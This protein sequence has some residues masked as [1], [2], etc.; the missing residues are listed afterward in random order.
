MHSYHT[1]IVGQV[2]DGLQLYIVQFCSH[3]LITN[4]NFTFIICFYIT[5][6][7]DTKLYIVCWRVT[8]CGLWLYPSPI[9]II[10]LGSLLCLQH[11]ALRLMHLSPSLHKLL[12][13]LWLPHHRLLLPK[14]SAQLSVASLSGSAIPFTQALENH[15][16]AAPLKQNCVCVCE[17]MFYFLIHCL[18]LVGVLFSRGCNLSLFACVTGTLQ[19]KQKRATQTN[20]N[21]QTQVQIP[22]VNPSNGRL[23]KTNIKHT[24]D[25]WSTHSQTNSQ[26]VSQAV[27]DFLYY[28]SLG[29]AVVAIL[30]FPC[31]VVREC[32]CVHA[33][34]YVKSVF[35]SLFS[36]MCLTQQRGGPS[37]WQ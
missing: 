21:K 15:P 33:C 1:K 6:D 11:D 32:V 13:T 9:Y 8:Q 5:F 36:S 26:S 35:G 23:A 4:Q 24:L 19:L 17:S 30:P 7:I 27:S 2:W 29:C 31:I 14:H 18:L 34:M 22:W 25:S 20:N 16:T 12:C 10:M 28:C 37:T 3:H